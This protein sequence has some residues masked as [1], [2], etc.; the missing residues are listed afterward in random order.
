MKP[1]VIVT[2]KEFFKAEALFKSCRKFSCKPAKPGER[3]LAEC[4]LRENA[5]AAVVGTEKYRDR[6]YRALPG[7]GVIARFGVGHDGIDKTKASE[8]GLLVTN[9]PGVL[10]GSVAEHAMILMASFARNIAAGHHEMKNG[11][12]NPLMGFELRGKTLLIIGCGPIGRKTAEIASRGFGMNVTGYDI[13]RLDSVRKKKSGFSSICSKLDRALAEADFVSLHVP[14]TPSTKHLVNSSFIS[15]MKPGCVLVN[16]ARGRLVDESAL[17]DALRNGRLSGAALDVF[18][19]EPFKPVNERK[20]LRGLDN[21]LLSPHVASG[22]IEA[23]AR[24]AAKCLK[25]IEHA[26]GKNYDNLNLLNTSVLKLL[27]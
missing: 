20:D 14:L 1:V 12:W 15:M 3:L 9:T 4:I 13:A 7:G 16:T 5:F 2:E 19:N 10:E 11:R 6:L 8:C 18:E 21:V 25:N 26:Y 24:M 22:T 27:K 17:Y 23:C